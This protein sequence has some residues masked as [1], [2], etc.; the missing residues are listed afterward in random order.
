MRSVYKILIW[1]LEG[2]RP[3]RRHRNRWEDD[4]RMDFKE[5]GWKDVDWLYL[6][7]DRK[8]WWAVVNT[9]TNLCIV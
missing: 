1:R 6:S 7:E 3:L 9:V 8:Q 4:S 5:T 2:K